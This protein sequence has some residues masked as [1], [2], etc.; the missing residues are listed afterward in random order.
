M[1]NQKKIEAKVILA[2][3]PYLH[4]TN[5]NL[6]GIRVQK[7]GD[8]W[9][10]TWTFKI[11]AIMASKEGYDKEFANGS[12]G[13]T[14]EYPGCPYCNATGFSQCSCG[15]IFCYKAEDGQN[16]KVVRRTCPWCGVTG[17]YKD[18]EKFELQGGG[19]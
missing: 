18:A 15:K 16:G 5:D 4:T 17:D 14:S 19:F 13:T 11:D 3:C 1:K 12:F 8:D 2:K 7:F 6:Y 9:I 10:R